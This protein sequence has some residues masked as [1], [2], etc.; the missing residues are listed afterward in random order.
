MIISRFYSA[1]FFL[2]FV[3]SSCQKEGCAIIPAAR[4]EISVSQGSALDLSISGNYVYF[5]DQG[6]AGVV[7]LNNNGVVHAYDL[8]STLNVEA[9]HSVRI[10]DNAYFWDESTGAKWLLDGTVAAVARCPLK[11][12]FVATVNEGFTYNV[13]Y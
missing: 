1:S 10:L 3:L 13:R 11:E 2:L 8:C 12:Y 7:L 6:Y 5:L 4:V 9:R